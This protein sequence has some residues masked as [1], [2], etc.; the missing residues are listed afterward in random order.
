MISGSP[1]LVYRPTTKTW[2]YPFRYISSEG[3]AVVVKLRRGRS[4]FRSTCVNP[5][6]SP[7]PQKDQLETKE[8]EVRLKNDEKDDLDLGTKAR[9]VKVKKG[10]KEE[11]EFKELRHKE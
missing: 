8:D 10:S 5:S 7:L 3:K 2:E 1:V 9:K 11:S 4:I 6:V